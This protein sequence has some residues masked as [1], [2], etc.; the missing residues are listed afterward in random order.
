MKRRDDFV[1]ALDAALEADGV[2]PITGEIAPSVVIVA[3]NWVRAA[4]DS[5]NPAYGVA[6]KSL[7]DHTLGKPQENVTL[8]VTGHTTLGMS[9][10][11]LSLFGFNSGKTIERLADGTVEEV[12]V[13]S[14]PPRNGHG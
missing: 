1:K 5:A 10:A 6:L 8:D 14:I 4:M 3:R 13:L 2:D 7:Q 12:E 9:P 11:G